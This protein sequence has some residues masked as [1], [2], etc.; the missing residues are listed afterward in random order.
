MAEL[1]PWIA[2]RL[3]EVARRARTRW[4]ARR[5][6]CP[7]SASS[8]RCAPSPGA[9]GCTG[10]ATS[11]SSPTTSRG[12][13]MERW[14]RRQ[15]RAEIA[16]AAGRAAPALGERYTKLTI[17]DQRTRWGSCSSSGAMSFNWRLLLGARGGPGLRRPARGR[18]LAVMDH[19]PRFWAL[20]ERHRP[21]YRR[22]GAGC[23]TTAR[24][25]SCRAERWPGARARAPRGRRDRGRLRRGGGG[26]ARPARR[27]AGLGRPATASTPTGARAITVVRRQR[28]GPRL[29]EWTLRTPALSDPTRVRV[30][31][32]AG[33]RTDATRRYPVLYLLH[34]ADSDDSV[35][36]P[37][38]RRRARSRPARR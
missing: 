8:S 35:V 13:A 6:R 3:A 5:T 7:T 19:S 34:G 20:M 15:A 1:R 4:P 31:L 22:R 29:E 14:Y 25:S 32:P 11:C 38:R 33:Y 18:H 12:A 10:A 21:G 17:R 28:L 36:D 37:L 2:R 23:A 30:L 26:G 24:R 27:T 9:R 16:P